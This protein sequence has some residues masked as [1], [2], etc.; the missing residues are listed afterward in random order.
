M[1]ICGELEYFQPELQ[2]KLRRQSRYLLSCKCVT[3]KYAVST[4]AFDSKSKER[5][6]IP[7]QGMQYTF[8]AAEKALAEFQRWVPPERKDTPQA[9]PKHSREEI[10]RQASG[11]SGKKSKWVANMCRHCRSA[12]CP[13]ARAKQR[14]TSWPST[15]TLSLRECQGR[16]IFAL[17]LLGH[18]CGR[19]HK[20]LTTLPTMPTYYSIKMKKA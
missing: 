20:R 12:P 17:S 15:A 16:Q 1:N 5:L 13:K 11:N 8:Q 10:Q 7:V 6:C 14:K 9:M 2:R 18:A 3:G 19:I 4:S